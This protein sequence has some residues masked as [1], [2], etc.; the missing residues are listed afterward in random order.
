MDVKVVTTKTVNVTRL[1][2][3]ARVRYWEDA[4]VGGVEDENGTL[5]PCRE[6]EAWRPV[7]DLATGRIENWK[8]GVVADIHYKICDD[9]EYWLSGEGEILDWRGAYV[10]DDLLCI[11]DTGHGDYIIMQ[12]DAKGMIYGWEEP[13]ISADEWTLR[14]RP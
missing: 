3:S 14:S 8:L 1:H 12:V 7:I 2:M 6:S 11:G 4:T 5:I 13:S 10:P 9:G